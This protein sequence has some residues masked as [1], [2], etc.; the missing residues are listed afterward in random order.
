MSIKETGVATVSR[1][2]ERPARTN[3][4]RRLRISRDRDLPEIYTLAELCPN[5]RLYAS[6]FVKSQVLQRKRVLV[7][8]AVTSAVRTSCNFGPGA[9]QA[10][11]AKA[12][13]KRITNGLRPT[14][15]TSP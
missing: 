13:V 12:A 4:N 15:R 9:Y 3:F 5:M 14:R 10:G 2:S 6:L 7:S 1:A 11:I 8:S